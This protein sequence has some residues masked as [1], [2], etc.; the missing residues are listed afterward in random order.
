MV[1]LNR[2]GHPTLSKGIQYR[3]TYEKYQVFTQKR[4]TYK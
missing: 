2:S 3:K 1:Q 4:F